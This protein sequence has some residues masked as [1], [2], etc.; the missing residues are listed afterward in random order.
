MTR[1]QRIPAKSRRSVAYAMPRFS[2]DQSRRSESRSPRACDDMPPI[3]HEIFILVA[4][5]IVPVASRCQIRESRICIFITKLG[6]A[7]CIPRCSVGALVI[8]QRFGA[9]DILRRGTGIIG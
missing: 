6:S 5:G 8:K 3:G 2:Y 7:S 4:P 9:H 1:H